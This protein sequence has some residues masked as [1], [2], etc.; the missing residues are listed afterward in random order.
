MEDT[1]K[2]LDIRYPTPLFFLRPGRIAEWKI[3]VRY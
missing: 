3:K 2:K 1:G